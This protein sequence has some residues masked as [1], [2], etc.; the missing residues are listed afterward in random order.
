MPAAPLPGAAASGAHAPGEPTATAAAAAAGAAE[1]GAVIRAPVRHFLS[2]E[3]LAYQDKVA[4]V[5]LN[6]PPEA[7]LSS[8]EVKAV[9]ASLRVDA[10]LQPLAPYLCDF[11][12]KQVA[13]SLESSPQRLGLLLRAAVCMVLNPQLD[14]GRYLHVMVPAVLTCLLARHIGNSVSGKEPAEHWEVRERAAVA[15]AALCQGYPEAAGR[16]QRQLVAAMTSH[17]AAL[18]TVYGAVAGIAAQGPRAVKALLLP[19]LIPVVASLSEDLQGKKGAA[20]AAMAL[21][22]RAR[23]LAAAGHCVY[24]SG[25]CGPWS[26]QA[27]GGVQPAKTKEAAAAGGE[28]VDGSKPRAGKAG[29]QLAKLSDAEKSAAMQTAAKAAAA[30]NAKGAATRAT[31]RKRAGGRRGG[32][33]KA[34]AS[35]PSASVEAVPMEE[36]FGEESDEDAGHAALAKESMAKVP[37]DSL[38]PAGAKDNGGKGGGGGVPGS[39]PEENYL[40][41]AWREEFPVEELHRAMQTLFGSDLEP[42]ENKD[43]KEAFL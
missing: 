4:Q 7:A 5:L 36:V 19:N 17:G 12:A 41:E 39:I 22:V 6:T 1:D 33:A 8:K 16:V 21:R 32:G 24:L 43:G 2:R 14:L 29:P 35:A 15:V 13:D 11:V 20:R 3:L 40:E 18:E 27:K 38:R 23:I 34:L 37:R 31:P 25:V 42:Y 9:L 26:V 10:G 30:A 28:L